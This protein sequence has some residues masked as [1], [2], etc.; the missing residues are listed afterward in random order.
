VNK[1]PKTG[2]T[3]IEQAI[4]LA[5]GLGSRMRPITESLP[6]PLVRVCG[7]PLLDYG[8]DCL[9][10]KSVKKAVVNVHYL[11]DEIEAYLAERKDIEVVFSDERQRL[12]DSGGGVKKALG[13]L[14]KQPFFLLNSDSFWLEGSTPNLSLLENCWD[15]EKMDMLLLL[16]P[17]TNAIGFSGSGDFDMMPDGILKRRAERKIAAFAYAGAA[18][19][20]PRIFTDTPDEP[21][22]LNLL[23]NKAIEEERLYGCRMNGLWLHVGTPDAIAEA[24]AAIAKSAA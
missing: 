8:L 21:F 24:E 18:I 11:A 5:A 4:V 9:A 15:E 14:G 7:K 10:R 16:S 19:I 2:N 12:L 17:M 3:P 23:F 6:K 20:H 1:T 13:Q 22:S